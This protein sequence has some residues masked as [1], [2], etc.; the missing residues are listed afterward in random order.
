M[1][2]LCLPLSSAL[3]ATMQEL[4][5]LTIQQI[6]VI[7]C[8]A[9]AFVAAVIAFIK[10]PASE[11]FSI[12]K[13]IKEP[14]VEYAP[15]Y[16]AKERV[17]LFLKNAVWV[18]PTY[19]FLEYWFFPNLGEY[20][21]NANCYNYGPINGVH[22]VFYGIFVFMPLFFALMVFAIS[23][24]EAIEVFKIGQYPLPNKKVLNLTKYKYGLSAKLHALLFFICIMG[25]FG[26][27]IWGGFQAHKLTQHIE[28][29]AANKSLKLTASNGAASQL[30]PV[31]GSLRAA[32]SGGSLALR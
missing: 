4:S 24:F 10:T 29:C 14:G 20:S 22:S 27:S 17:M 12:G 2:R 30:S 7:V 1:R 8:L 18:V 19:L 5:F 26:I 23:G 16:T 9:I 13:P 25:F 32:R 28:P 3:A 31:F 6:V 15:M 11:R 21:S